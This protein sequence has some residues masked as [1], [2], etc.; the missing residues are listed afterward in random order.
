MT[1]KPSP[2]AL[3]RS[4]PTTPIACWPIAACGAIGYRG[5]TRRP[6]RAIAE[7]SRRNCR[8]WRDKLDLFLHSYSLRFHYLHQPGFDVFA[9]IRRAVADGFDGV[10]INLNATRYRHL[11]GD[12]PEHIAAVRRALD[13]AGLKRDIETSGTDPAHLQQ[14]LDVARKLGANN[15]RTYTRHHGSTAEQIALTAR[16][17]RTAAPLAERAGVAILLEN[18]EEF[19]GGEL[20][21]ILRAVGSDW[22]CAL[23]D[24]G[25]SQMCME[26][27][28]DCLAAM[29][30]YIRTAHLKDH[31]M[32]RAADAPDGRLRVMGVPI[33][34]GNLEILETTHRLM[35]AGVPRVAFEN[36]WAYSAPVQRPDRDGLLGRGVFA[37]VDPP[38]D[39]AHCAPDPNALSPEQ[40]V[41]YEDQALSRSLA[42]LRRH[43][44]EAGLSIAEAKPRPRPAKAAPGPSLLR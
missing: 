12:S 10:N 32:L 43:F 9:F 6:R 2:S 30:P 18:H 7:R 29:L 42:W 19:T 26:D 27:P 35:A 8:R 13:E 41:A 16:D 24:Y 21:D 38:F 28:L 40:R 3:R 20:V 1:T 14:L 44:Q 5:G 25:N 31:M 39:P 4:G 33:G 15:L 11:S 37:Y 23:Y 22:V 17:L 34:E 36:V